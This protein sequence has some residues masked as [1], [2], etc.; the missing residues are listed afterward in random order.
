MRLLANSGKMTDV[1]DSAVNDFLLILE[2]HRKNC[3]RQG[4]YVEAEIAKNRLEELKVHEE[5][6]RREAMRSRQIAERLGVEEAHML[7]F[8]QFNQVWDRKMDEYERNVEELVVNMREK[9]KSELL[10]FQQKLLEKNQKPKFSKDLLNLRR[11]EEHLA[12]QKDYGEA[13]KIK[14]KSDALEAWELEKWRNL[15]QQEMFQREVTFK[16]RQKQDLDALQKR[17]QS[18]REE[19]KKQRQID[20]ERLL[21]RYQNVKAELQQQQNLERIRHEKFAQRAK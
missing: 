11:I 21:Q 4:K 14:L 13:H 16:Q 15:K 12:R 2:E 5:T 10:E 9:H 1:E 7:E 6:R 3:E 19:Q 18:G 8:Q 20:L 17:I